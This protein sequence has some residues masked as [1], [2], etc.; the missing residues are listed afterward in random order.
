[1][2]HIKYLSIHS[3]H[4][5]HNQVESQ[6][7]LQLNT[8]TISASEPLTRFLYRI[9]FIDKSHPSTIAPRFKCLSCA[10]ISL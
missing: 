5:F 6:R 10:G 1:M 7:S 8:L 3:I 9:K 4:P 2:T